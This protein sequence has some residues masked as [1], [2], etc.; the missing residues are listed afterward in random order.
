[1]V[2]RVAE[3]I[4]KL[5]V[6]KGLTQEQAANA[7]G[8]S[9]TTYAGIEADKRDLTVGGLEK[10]AAALAV[11]ICDL[12]DRPRD[13][14]K[15]RQMYHYILRHFPNGVPKTK[16]AKLL[17]LAD[18][19]CYYDT[20]QPMSGVS[21]IRREYGPVADIFFET[22]DDQHEKG[23]IRIAELDRAMM[24]VSTTMEPLSLLTDADRERLDEICGIWKDK[25]V[26]EIVN[27]THEQKPWKACRNG[28]AIP[29]SLII[30]EEPDRVLAPP[31]KR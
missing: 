23:M 28:E 27:F 15:F 26:A 29:Y 18:F 16:L 3:N 12:L 31:A 25:P 19:S 11:S 21:Y 9:R 8:V 5:R 24:I 1:V 17:Y 30:Q 14:E 22:T 20:L 6:S 10:L 2:S 4:K 7:M 13:D